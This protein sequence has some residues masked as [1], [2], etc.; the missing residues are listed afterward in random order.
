[1]LNKND[2]LMSFLPCQKLMDI[3]L[4]TDYR[5]NW[6]PLGPIS[7]TNHLQMASIIA[8]KWQS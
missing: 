5:P 7:I 6:S 4:Q 8:Y 2:R 3:L 1:M